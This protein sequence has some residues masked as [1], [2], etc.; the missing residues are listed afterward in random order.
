MSTAFGH[1]PL[2]CGDVPAWI[3]VEV[4]TETEIDA[5]LRVVA[6]RINDVAR[7]WA[8]KRE[9]P[10]LQPQEIRRGVDHQ[11]YPKGNEKRAVVAEHQLSH[12]RMQAV[13]ADHQIEAVWLIALECYENLR[14]VLLQRSDRIVKYILAFLARFE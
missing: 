1:Q 8:A 9:F 11:T 4:H 6:C 5:K 7:C 13:G 2:L 10:V 14:V 3:L 12:I